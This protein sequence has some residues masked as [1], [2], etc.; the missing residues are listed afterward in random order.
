VLLSW[1]ARGYS[2]SLSRERR[3]QRRGRIETFTGLAETQEG[4]STV[5]RLFEEKFSKV[6]VRFASLRLE[7]R[8]AKKACLFQGFTLYELEDRKLERKRDVSTVAFSA[9]ALNEI[10]SQKSP[11]ELCP[12]LLLHLSV[13]QC[14]LRGI[15]TASRGSWK[16]TSFCNQGF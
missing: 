14:T 6:L 11:P 3:R 1:F 4:G 7:R 10:F 12:L 5:L 8:E 9:F 2:L 16:F 15:K 13:F